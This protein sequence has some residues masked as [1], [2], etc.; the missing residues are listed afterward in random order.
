MK[1]PVLGVR[2]PGQGELSKARRVLHLVSYLIPDRERSSV[3]LTTTESGQ[4]RTFSASQ[5]NTF[6]NCSRK[7]AYENIAKLKPPPSYPMQKG[8]YV[9]AV[10]EDFNRALTPLGDRSIEELRSDLRESILEVAREVW[11]EGM[12]GEFEDQLRGDHESVRTQF[13]HYVDSVIKRYRD[14]RRRT[15]LDEETAW[16]RAR[17]TANEVSVAV[18]DDAGEWVFRGDVDAVYEK[19][20]LWFGA[21]VL[22][23]Y[24]TGSSPFNSHAPL[25]VN[26]G[27][28]LDIYAWMFYQA[29]GVVPE[30]T[31]L[32]FLDEEPT[33]PTA[34]VFQETD[35][36]TVEQVHLMLRRVRNRATSED[37]ESYE[38]NPDYKWCEFTKKDGTVLRCDHWDYCLGEE[39]MPEPGDPEFTGR[40]RE[41][42][43]VPL[44][45]PLEDDLTLSR[46]APAVLEARE[47]PGAPP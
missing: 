38:K 36:G 13:F 44:R 10:V 43:D 22:I 20:P 47:G 31:G 35:A 33:S 34:F 8:T 24:K 3:D 16:R 4:L 39:T 42:L 9:H 32:H 11:K 41:P 12:V 29:F 26:Y 25:D 30:V 40:Q 1:P 19:H 2:P 5:I 23:D 45:N 14:L 15:D 46:N 28:Q 6:Y 21:T 17:P 37:V 18:T 7:W 27:R